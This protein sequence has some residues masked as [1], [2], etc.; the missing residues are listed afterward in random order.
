[1]PED[2]KEALEAQNKK[3]AEELKNAPKVPI[4]GA[5]VGRCHICGQICDI[6]DLEPFDMHVGHGVER[7]AGP[8]CHPYRTING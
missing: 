3:E 7:R 2:N 5:I 6:A 4:M 1:M 8:C